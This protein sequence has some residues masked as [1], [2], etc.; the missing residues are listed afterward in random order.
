MAKKL[1]FVFF[2][3]IVGILFL[4]VENAIHK[5][6]ATI[7]RPDGTKTTFVKAINGPTIEDKLKMIASIT[8]VPIQF[9]GIVVDENGNGLQGVHIDH[10][11]FSVGILSNV[12][13][14][15]NILHFTTTSGSDGAFT[16]KNLR[17]RLLSFDGFTKLGYKLMPSQKNGFA[18]A[19][20]PEIHTPNSNQPVMFVMRSDGQ[21]VKITHAQGEIRLLWDGMPVLASLTTGKLA[22]DGDLVIIA[23]RDA[24][25]GKKIHGDFSWSLTLR[26]TN[27]ELLEAKRDTALIAPKDGYKDNWT[28]RYP[29]IDS[30]LLGI[31]PNIY[32]KKNGAYG[33]LRLVIQPDSSPSQ[34][35]LRIEIFQSEDGGRITD[36]GKY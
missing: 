31:H 32:F 36:D 18:Y 30:N 6:T 13:F 5:T 2:V 33:R 17:G 12:G 27:G 9:F 26:L 29:G 20:S 7:I 1:K 8:N 11:V 15:D 25:I 10:S 3:T 23:Q 4:W 28:I 16:V 35:S 24:E 21:T 19:N 14:E 22:K 34:M